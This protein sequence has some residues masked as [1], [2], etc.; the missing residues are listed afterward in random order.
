MIRKV[1]ELRVNYEE[2]ESNEMLDAACL[3]KAAEDFLQ[4]LLANGLIAKFGEVEVEY[5]WQLDIKETVESEAGL[6][7]ET[8]GL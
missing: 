7:E 2:N 3:Q 1:F 8:S 4:G 5:L 6:N